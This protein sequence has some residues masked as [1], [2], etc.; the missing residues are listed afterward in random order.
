MDR[1]TRI[2]W[3]VKFTCSF[4]QAASSTGVHSWCHKP[5]SRAV[6][7]TFCPPSHVFMYHSC[8]HLYINDHMFTGWFAFSLK[9]IFTISHGAECEGIVWQ[10]K[11]STAI[12]DETVR[13]GKLQR[14][15]FTHCVDLL[16]MYFEC[17]VNLIYVGNF[18]RKYRAI[19]YVYNNLGVIVSSQPKYISNCTTMSVYVWNYSPYKIKFEYFC[20][21]LWNTLT[22]HKEKGWFV[23]S[24]M[25]Y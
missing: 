21:Q 7:D 1:R 8:Y 14:L 6:A 20:N 4:I 5:S 11:R 23:H 15:A 25:Q 17:F 9:R 16:L 12:Y 13:T 22:Q 3:K 10:E 18:L 19:C 24:T 2:E